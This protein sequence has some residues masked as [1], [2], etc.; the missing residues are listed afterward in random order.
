MKKGENKMKSRAK[1]NQSK[2]NQMKQRENNA[3][4]EINDE[5]LS[6]S[7]PS[8]MISSQSRLQNKYYKRN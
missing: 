2:T 1:Q 3:K 4:F 6:L 5:F 7:R 8:G